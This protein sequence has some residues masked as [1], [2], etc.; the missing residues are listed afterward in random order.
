[1]FGLTA[2]RHFTG[3]E[4]TLNTAVVNFKTNIS[5]VNNMDPDEAPPSEIQIVLIYMQSKLQHFFM[6]TCNFRKFSNKKKIELKY[7]N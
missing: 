3:H 2:L 4:L 7:L 6:E 1:L 5:K